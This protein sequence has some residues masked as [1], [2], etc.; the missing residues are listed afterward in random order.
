[1]KKQSNFHAPSSHSAA[2]DITCAAN[3]LARILQNK[4]KSIAECIW[5]SKQIL[6][7]IAAGTHIL[8]IK[9]T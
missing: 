7:C 2:Y 4:K 9:A 8:N 6:H 3:F 5:K 1:M